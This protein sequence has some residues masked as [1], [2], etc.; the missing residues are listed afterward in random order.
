MPIPD[1][2]KHD[3]GGAGLDIER[4]MH[5]RTFERDSPPR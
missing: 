4:G 5:R 2:L 3:G 1:L